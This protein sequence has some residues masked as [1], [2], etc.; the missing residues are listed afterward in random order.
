[1]KKNEEIKMPGGVYRVPVRRVFNK[2]H[3][4]GDPTWADIYGKARCM[5]CHKH[6]QEGDAYTVIVVLKKDTKGNEKFEPVHKYLHV[7][8]P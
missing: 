8:C 2:N 3:V 6:F 1:M 4:E 5:K 7:E